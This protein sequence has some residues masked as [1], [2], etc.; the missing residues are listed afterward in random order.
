[1]DIIHLA[2]FLIY[3]ETCSCH[4]R[5]L[6]LDDCQVSECPSGTTKQNRETTFEKSKQKVLLAVQWRLHYYTNRTRSYLLGELPHSQSASCGNNESR[7][8]GMCDV[9]CNLDAEQMTASTATLWLVSLALSS[10]TSHISYFYQS[11]NACIDYIFKWSKTED[12]NVHVN[13]HVT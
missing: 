1:M 13:V 9:T 3:S 5:W 4:L 11:K 12:T 2:T 6:R 7:F 8:L 10:R